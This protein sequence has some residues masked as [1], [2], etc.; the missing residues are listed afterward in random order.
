MGD[1]RVL[2]VDDRPSVA[3]LTA[4]YLRRTGEGIDVVTAGDAETGIERLGSKSIDCVVS[5]YDMPGTDGLEFLDAVWD[6][7]PDLPFVLFTGKGSEEIASEAISAGVTDYLQ[8]GIGTD[9]YEVLAN[10][11]E[12]AVAQHRAERR[13]AEANRQMRR[14]YRRITDA[15]YALDDEWRFTYVNEQAAEFLDRSAE[16]L[17]GEDIREAF[18]EG[19]GERFHDAYVEAVET[20]EPVTLTAASVFQ[21]GRWVEEQV[22]P[23][24]DGLSVYFRDVTERR[25]RDQTLNALHDVTRDL[26]QAETDREIADIVCEVADTVLDFPGTGV[27]LYDADRAALVN[28]ALGGEYVRDVDS[29][30]TFGVE[31]SP[32]GRAYREG[33]TVTHEVGADSSWGLE[34]FERTMYVP[35]G[36][37]GVL[38]VAKDDGEPFDD[39]EV[40]FAEILTE[41]ARAALDR[42]E[43]EGELREREEAL[44]RQNERLEEFASVVSHDL[45]NPL[46]VARGHLELARETGRD[47]SFEVVADAHDRMEALVNDLLELAQQGQTVGATEE[48]SLAAVAERAWA[49]VATEGATLNLRDPGTVEADEARLCNLFENLFRN[50]VE[51]GSTDSPTSSDDAGVTVTVAATESGFVVTDDG[52]GIPANER[53]HVFEYGYSTEE[54]GIG[55]GLSIVKG[56]ADAHGWDLSV[57][58]EDDEPGGPA[59]GRPAGFEGSGGVS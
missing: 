52:P 22:F 3:D 20:Q 7:E 45:R 51:H 36:D 15:F 17:V 16:E 27:R 56:I 55:L 10:R 25:R 12:N 5:D 49:N 38:S 41:N 1:I 13:A 33:E 42:A 58:G 9:Q 48:V 26:M 18:P 44:E 29:R 31:D 14:M 43:R 32:H 46:N 39:A 19:V 47:E 11:I 23:A 30:P 6:V 2:L 54:D 28:V 35:M 8:K 34:A 4:T 40:R 57:S 59:A 50:S 21:P 37:H 53:E 24:E